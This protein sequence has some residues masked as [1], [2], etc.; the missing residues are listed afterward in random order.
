MGQFLPLPPT[1]RA[2]A[3]PHKAAAPIVRHRG[4]YGPTLLK[5]SDYRPA[6]FFQRRGCGFQ[7]QTRGAS[8]SRSD[9]MERVLNRSTAVNSINR[10]CRSYFGRFATTLHLG[11]F[12]QNR[13][14]PDS[15]SAANRSLFD[16]IIGG[17]EQRL[18]DSEAKR[19]CGYSINHKIELGRLL[20]GNVGR[21]CPAQ[22]LVNNFCG[23]SP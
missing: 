5:K 14:Q 3:L 4:R 22:N 17:G 1:E 9:S 6:Q 21:L 15:C 10:R 7:M 2:A 13:P 20:H 16:Q 23:A 19:L 18:R 8:S 12:Q 11:L